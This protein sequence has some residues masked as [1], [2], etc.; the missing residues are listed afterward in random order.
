M[1]VKVKLTFAYVVSIVVLAEDAP[2]LTRE[3]RIYAIE[4]QYS[5]N[6]KEQI[7][8]F[9]AELAAP[10]DNKRRIKVAL[11]RVIPR[12]LPPGRDLAVL[13]IPGDKLPAKNGEAESWKWTACMGIVTG[14]GFV[15]PGFR[16]DD[17]E[18]GG[19]GS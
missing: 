8:A 17:T 4:W 10:V 15:F 16:S 18:L 5:K 1:R 2:P 9:N 6:A 14:D 11:S 7:D 19:E 13:L 3:V 12:R